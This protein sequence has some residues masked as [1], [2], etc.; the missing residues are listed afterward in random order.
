MLGETVTLNKIEYSLQ[1]CG[2]VTEN[3]SQ[4]QVQP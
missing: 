3:Q 2:D 4:I 1:Q